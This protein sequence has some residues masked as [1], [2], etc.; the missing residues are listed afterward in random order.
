MRSRLRAR[1]L[2]VTPAAYMRDPC[3]VP[4]LSQSIAHTIVEH[5]PLHAWTRHPRLGAQPAPS[6][7]AM[8]EG[9]LLH[10]LLLGCGSREIAV[11]PFDEYKSN[12]AKSARDEAIA[13]GK[14]PVKER[15]HAQAAAAAEKL[16]RRCAELGFPFTGRSELAI[17]WRERGASDGEPVLCRTMLDH[18]LIE[19]GVIYDLKKAANA[20]PKNCEKS[21]SDRGYDIQYAAGTRALAALRPEFEGRIQF[22]FLFLE[23]EPPYDVVPA[24][25]SGELRTIGHLRWERAVLRW[26]ECLATGKWPGYCV[27]G[28]PIILQARPWALAAEEQGAYS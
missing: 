25:P 19:R 14:L 17:E 21:F 26:Q 23:L 28:K 6:T 24:Q 9:T 12:A 1:I 15:A 11:I 4:S 27:D 18:V 10:R 20:S 8:D 5:S 22:T 2:N 16:R 3:K 7:A 13:A